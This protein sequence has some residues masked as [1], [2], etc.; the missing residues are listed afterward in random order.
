MKSAQEFMQYLTD[1]KKSHK[2]IEERGNLIK[3]FH[4]ALNCEPSTAE[5]MD[6]FVRKRWSGYVSRDKN[7]FQ[8]LSD[9]ADFCEQTANVFNEFVCNTFEGEARKAM[10]TYKD[11]MVFIPS[12]TKIDPTH[13]NGLTNDEFVNAFLFLQEFLY[14]VYDAIEH[15]SPFEWGWPNW[16][17][18][19]WYGI[20]HNRVIMVLNALVECGDIENN[21][22]VVDKYRFIEHSKKRVDEQIICRP[23]QKTRLLL[24]GLTRMGLHIEGLD[25]TG[26][27]HFIVSFPNDPNVITVI[28]SYFKERN[29]KI[30]N[31]IRYFSYR[32]VED[33]AS[34]THE[35]LFLAMT[36]GE[37]E[38]LREIYYWLYD[39][40][41]RYGF[42]P[43]G[44]EK[45]HCYLYKKG[46]KE[47]LLLGKGS[48]YHESEFLHSINY[49][50]A[51]KFGF[52]KTYYTHP[53][54]IEW[55][56]RR[57]PTAFTSPWGG[58]HKC[59]AIPEDCKHRVIFDHTNYAC[60]KGYF[61]FHDPTFDDVKEI[62]ELYKIENKI[63]PLQ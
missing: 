11:S 1:K 24:E 52:Q 30:T 62:L 59:K 47:W 3:E 26:I 15:G 10:K 2:H 56:K 32:F 17:N 63:K 36:D 16:S 9:Y 60:I 29:D 39:K 5:A 23:H 8:I 34:Q 40:A 61:Y 57:F 13:L 35:P 41:V 49:S 53:E 50:I 6:A 21:A 28:C 44:R 42:E 33:S 54:K 58:C 7:T 27:P 55:L 46:T 4:I 43:T 20:I 19:T 48:S 37:P 45:M 31:H 22:L 38:H 18:L 51:A 12:N 14:A 25:D